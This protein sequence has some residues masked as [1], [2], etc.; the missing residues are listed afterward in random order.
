MQESVDA[1]FAD[2][3]TANIGDKNPSSLGDSVPHLRR[4]F[5]SREKEAG[6]VCFVDPAAAANGGAQW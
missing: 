1:A 5:D 3:F 6:S 4:N 2:A